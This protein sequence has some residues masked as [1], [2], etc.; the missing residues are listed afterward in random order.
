MTQTHEKTEQQ[1]LME[2]ASHEATRLQF[3]N[4]SV[5]YERT[6]QEFEGKVYVYR[7]RQNIQGVQYVYSYTHELC[8]ML[9][10]R[11]LFSS[12]LYDNMQILIC[13]FMQMLDVSPGHMCESPLHCNFIY[14]D[15]LWATVY[16]SPSTIHKVR[17]Y[18]M[19][20]R[21]LIRFY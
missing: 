4:T 3:Q 12:Y 10:K 1:L 21:D 6:Q 14:N 7:V 13:S 11:L 18:V 20:L 16:S 8:A 9:S 2:K 19:D 15:C 17:S 5:D